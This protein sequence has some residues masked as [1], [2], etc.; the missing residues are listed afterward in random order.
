MYTHYCGWNIDDIELYSMTCEGALGDYTG[1]G[2]IDLEDY[3]GF[4]ACFSDDG[5]GLGPGC[6]VFD[7]NDDKYVDDGDIAEF[8]SVFDGPHGTPG[9][10]A[11]FRNEPIPAT[12]SWG[13]AI[14][15]LLAITTGTLLFHR[16]G[17][18]VLSD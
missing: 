7:F 16:P 8:L 10:A 4:A 5:G 12:S 18:P 2:D 1:D 6:A 17:A 3:A 9:R 15:T 11:S 13:L 14:M